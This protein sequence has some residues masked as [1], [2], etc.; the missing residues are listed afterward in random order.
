MK[1][2]RWKRFTWDLK[3]LPP[4]APQLAGRYS[5]RP[6]SVEDRAAVTKIVLSSLLLDPTWADAMAVGREWLTSQIDLSFEREAV[7]A[8]VLTH[9]Q[10]V[11]AASVITS[12][13]DAESHLL[14]G[15]CVSMEYRSRGMGSAL[16]YHTL[17]ALRQAGLRQAHGLTKDG[18][19][20]AK[21]VYPKYGATAVEY[22]F[23]PMPVPPA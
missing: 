16:L 22:R 3:E 19:Q 15:P 18:M 1:F 6:A 10:R 23:Q 7:P 13:P 9:G 14:S 2:V 21:F 12:E 17:T 11:V 20:A 4:S 5:V 8:I